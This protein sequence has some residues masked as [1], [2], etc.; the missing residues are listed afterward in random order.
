MTVAD[1]TEQ[2]NLYTL[3]DEDGVEQ[4]YELLDSMELD[5]KT[6]FALSPYYDDPSKALEDSG[7]ILILAEELDGDDA[8]MVSIEDDEEYQRVGQL[9]VDRLNRLFDGDFDEEE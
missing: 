8:Y 9:F 5:D 6:Y 4:V 3:M 2:G 1:R 7:E